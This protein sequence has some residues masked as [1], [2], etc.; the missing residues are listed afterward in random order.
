MS[1]RTFMSSL[2]R[3]LMAARLWRST[4]LSLSLNSF[5]GKGADYS[6]TASLELQCSTDFTEAF[7]SEELDVWH[8]ASLF[9]DE[10][11]NTPA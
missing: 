5:R 9:V 11:I 3:N 2:L 7:H 8:G 6:Q 10:L 4:P 1:I